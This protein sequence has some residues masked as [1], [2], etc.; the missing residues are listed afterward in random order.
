MIPLPHVA[1]Q[2]FFVLGFGKS[3]QASASALKAAGARILVWDDKESTRAE[4]A[5]FGFETQSPETT[6]WRAIQALVMAPGVPLHHP[7]PH[8]AVEAAREA[9]TPILSDLDLLFAACPDAT[10]IGITGTNGK[11][12]TTALIAHILQS[13][14]RNVQ[15]GGNIGTAA[16]SLEPLGKDGIYVL[17]LS[18][19]QLDLLQSNPLA[20]A[21]LLNVT[22]DHFAR[23]GGLEGYIEAKMKIADGETPQILI[24]GTDEPETKEILSR[25]QGRPHLRIQ[26]ISSK[27]QPTS[28]LSTKSGILS[29]SDG[30]EPI[31]LSPFKTLPGAH[32]AQNAGAAVL[33]C[34]ALGLGRQEIIAGLASFSGLAHRQ[35]LVETIKSVRFINDS[36]ATNADAA[37]KALVCYNN[38]YWIAGGQP[39]EGGLSGLEAYK[40]HVAHAFLIG[41]AMNAFSLW[42]EAKGIPF[43]RCETLGEATRQAA[44]KAWQDGR[45]DAV[46]L[47]S[48]AC[49]SWDQFGSFEERGEKFRDIV[50]DLK[51]R[52]S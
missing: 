11:S 42:C 10:Y 49:A 16:L 31:D 41:E 44:E 36:K 27:N 5:S 47:L 38:I 1:G 21:V 6:D 39:K 19:Y 26:E 24:L 3:G 43:S 9:Q 46:V 15:M 40:P 32:N 17:E 48:P 30:S 13:A 50:L 20:V 14:G 51:K 2:T 52:R 34:Q 28:G 7:K 25:L 37:A 8:P 4:A 18:S 29:F 12:T 23:H 45:K 35:Q 33:A 22:P